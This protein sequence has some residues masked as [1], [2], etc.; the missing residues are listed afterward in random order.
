MTDSDPPRLTLGS[1]LARALRHRC[2]VCGQS[3]MFRNWLQMESGC[4]NCGLK[5]ERGPGFFL[6]SAYINYGLT[7]FLLTI[8][9]VTLHFGMGYENRTLTPFL[10]GFCVLFPVFFFRYARSLWLAMDCFFD[11]GSHDEPHSTH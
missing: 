9:Y 1:A 10:V 11:S 2:P 3:A 5:Y 6:G 4:A 8:S 7:A